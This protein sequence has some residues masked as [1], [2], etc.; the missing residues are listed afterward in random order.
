[1]PAAGP[2]D[3]I[4]VIDLTINVLG[5]LATQVLGDA[6]ADIIKIEAPGGDPMR[7]LGPCRTQD[8]G[9]YFLNTNRNKRSVVL[10]LTKQGGKAALT[11]LLQTADVFVHNMRLGAIERLGFGYADVAA[12]N[13]GLIYASA[14]GFRRDS[15]YRDRPAFDDVIQ[16]MSGVAAL[17]SAIDGVPR[18]YPTVIAD[19]FTGHSLATAITMALFARTRTGR[20]QQ[21]HVPMMETML[22]FNLVEHLWGATLRD[23]SL[24]LS[25]SRVVSPH[26]RPYAT[27]DGHICLMAV[28]DDQWR[29]LLSAPGRASLMEDPRF[30]SLHARARNI[31]FVYGVLTEALPERT[32]AEWMTILDEA[33]VPNGPVNTV[34]DLLDDE[35]L[36]ETGFFIP[37]EHPTEG[38]MNMMAIPTE[39]DDTPASIRR[40]PPVLGEHTASVLREAGLTDAEIEAAG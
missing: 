28:T 17:N 7:K 40:L 19:K 34:Q 1:M 30:V 16:G 2:L 21:L 18:Y 33:D 3:G 12:L 24:G 27:K 20:G 22:A 5:P 32:T 14:T 4:R 35:Y 8:M 37:V 39:Y 9:T 23:P 25:Y 13:P 29:R 15:R 36:A 6:G 11:K 26:R 38:A 10:D 31:D